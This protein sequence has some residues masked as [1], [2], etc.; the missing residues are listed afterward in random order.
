MLI[1]GLVVLWLRLPPVCALQMI[2]REQHVALNEKLEGRD[3][4]VCVLFFPP[5]LEEI[6][7]VTITTLARS[8]LV[9]YG[10]KQKTKKADF[11]FQNP[12]LHEFPLSAP[13]GEKGSFPKKGVLNQRC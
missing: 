5:S 10:N 8:H 7:G 13:W 2:C 3:E 11:A 4:W 6:F 12:S 1:T 9:E